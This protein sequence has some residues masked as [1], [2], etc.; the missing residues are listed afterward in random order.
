MY[1]DVRLEQIDDDFMLP[2]DR[3]LLSLLQTI[4]SRPDLARMV[5]NL[6]IYHH[7]KVEVHVDGI[8]EIYQMAAE[9][10]SLTLL[11]IWERMKDD[12]GKPGLTI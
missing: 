1:H 5:K 9:A 7:Y 4:V 11:D 12:A 3:R 10:L 8:R 6:R 2:A